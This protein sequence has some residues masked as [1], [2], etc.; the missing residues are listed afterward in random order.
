MRLPEPRGY[1]S[2]FDPEILVYGGVLRG[3]GMYRASEVRV[4]TLVVNYGLHDEC[5]GLGYHDSRQ[6]QNTTYE[7][8]RLAEY[9]LELANDE[10]TR[11][12]GTR[13]RMGGDT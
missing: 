13:G 8:T 3:D 10:A 11:G 12:G 9:A 4:E 1:R 7:H 2:V 6:G 5:I